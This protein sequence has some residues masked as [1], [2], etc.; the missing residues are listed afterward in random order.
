MITFTLTVP[1]EEDVA[2]LMRD[3]AERWSAAGLEEDRY[4]E[5]AVQAAWN[6]GAGTAFRAFLKA[7]AHLSLIAQD[8]RG[9]RWPEICDTISLSRKEASGV[10]GAAN[11]RLKGRPP[12]T[13]LQQG[14]EYWFQMRPEVANM[15]I[16]LAEGE[17]SAK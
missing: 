3:A 16:Q 10:L 12:F 13:R 9:V 7:L 6:G 8:P 14:D 15:I 4:S 1:T 11:K 2:D 17:G 5:K